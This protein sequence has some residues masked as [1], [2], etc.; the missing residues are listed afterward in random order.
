[1]SHAARAA[2]A[3]ALLAAWAAVAGLLPGA[4]AAATISVTTTD[5]AV[6][7]DGACSLRE[8]VTSA[9]GPNA[10]G[11]GCADG[12]DGGADTIVLGAGRYTLGGAALD[13]ANLSGDLDVTKSVDIQGAGAGSTIVDAADLDRAFDVQ[14]DGDATSVS[15]TIQELTIRNGN[16]AG[17]GSDGDGGGV[18]MRDTNGYVTVRDAVIEDSDADRW[19]GALSFAGSTNGAGNPIAIVGSELRGNTAGDDG[20]AVYGSLFANGADNGL[21]VDRSTLTDN[22]TTAAGGAVYGA[23]AGFMQIVVRNSTL[24]G[25]SADEGGGAVALGAGYA[26]IDVRFSTITANTTSR[27]GRSRRAGCRRCRPPAT[28]CW[29]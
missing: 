4:A 10:V 7:A 26:E 21:L 19:G 9:N 18:R 25:N 5:D 1:M 23:S 17:A 12:D 20:G 14:S 3:V 29:P 6:V 15:G 11:S 8:A 22:S 24:N 27:T 16:A 2:R 13:D 28:W